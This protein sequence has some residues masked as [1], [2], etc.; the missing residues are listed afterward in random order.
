MRQQ[1]AIWTGLAL[2][3]MLSAC[4]NSGESNSATTSP[5][6]TP[7]PQTPPSNELPAD[8]QS[9]SADQQVTGGTIKVR[10]QDSEL[11]PSLSGYIVGAQDRWLL[12]REA[13]ASED[14]I[15]RD[16]P[17]G[18][19]DLIVLANRPI[20]DETSQ[21]LGQRINGIRVDLKR[22]SILRD[23][24]LSPTITLQG[25][26]R[27]RESPLESATVGIPGTSLQATSDANGD[28]SIT[29]VPIGQHHMTLTAEGFA[30]GVISM[31][32]ITQSQEDPFDLPGILL[33]PAEEVPSTGLYPEFTT[34]PELTR[35]FI[36]QA[37][38]T[39][40]QY[41]TS[42]NADMSDASWQPLTSTFS[43]EFDSAGEK[44]L[45]IQFSQHGKQLSKVF[46]ARLNI[47]E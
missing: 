33:L 35:V 6:P 36:A 37:P 17:A 23:V 20:D 10:L 24:I 22:P 34:S 3:G 47:E 19:Y 43:Y 38:Q 28:Y 44:T 27:R 31:L 46:S 39:A 8:D 30:N 2:A 5:A 41:R 4:A 25:N 42:E 26:V 1:T 12:E 14:Y 18:R 16:L 40:N 11:L 32:D 9:Q 21:L 15:I 45:Y 13:P 29:G 7:I